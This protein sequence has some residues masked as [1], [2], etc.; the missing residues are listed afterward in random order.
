MDGVIAT[1]LGPLTTDQVARYRRDGFVVAP[2]MLNPDLVASCLEALSAIAEGKTPV[3]ESKAMLERSSDPA[4][5]TEAN[6]L[7]HVRKF[8]DFTDD[9]PALRRAAMLRPLHQAIDQL[10]GMGRVLFQ[11][12]ALVKPPRI[13]SAKRWHQDAAY[14]RVSDPNLIVGVWIA[15]DRSTRINGCMQAIPGS[16]LGGPVPHVPMGDVNECHIRPDLVHAE[17]A[18]LIEM[19]PGDALIFH[20]CLHHYTA[21][22]ESE[23]RRRALQFHYHQLGMDWLDLAAHR[24]DFQDESGTY[25]GCT[26]A[27]AP[28]PD[29]ATYSYR[30]GRPR[31]IEL[32]D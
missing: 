21:P 1:D 20:A 31:A 29:G 17:R 15:L 9:F 8:V 26:V 18:E 23:L 5:I 25:A 14:F 4:G 2:G 3:S 10:M 11:E 30:P 24:R 32:Q 22:N 7:D 12:M 6:R 13:G 27:A 28:I 19:Q 16:H